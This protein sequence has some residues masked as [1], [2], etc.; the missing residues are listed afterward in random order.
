MAAESTKR[1]VPTHSSLTPCPW[2]LAAGRVVKFELLDSGRPDVPTKWCVAPFVAIAFM[3]MS[4]LGDEGTGWQVG[5]AYKSVTNLKYAHP[6]T[7]DGICISRSGRRNHVPYCGRA[8]PGRSPRSTYTMSH[9][10]KQ[11]QLSRRRAVALLL[12][13]AGG[14]ALAACGSPAVPVASPTVFSTPGSQPSMPRRAA[15]QP[16][17]RPPRRAPAACCAMASPRKLSRWR[18][19]RATI[20]RSCRGCMTRS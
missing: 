12:S 5:D 6:G 4:S 3:A 1:R 17:R 7:A 2:P 16:H 19:T 9:N 13:T 15:P 8:T 20:S 14:V 18:S 10:L 11:M